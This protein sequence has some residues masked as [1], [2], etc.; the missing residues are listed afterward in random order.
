MGQRARRSIAFLL[1]LACGLP[2]FADGKREV[3]VLYSLGSDASSLWQRKLALGISQEVAGGQGGAGPEL[4]EERLDAV[5]TGEREA[6]GA[7][8]PYLRAKYAQVGIDAV[9]AENYQACRFL[10]EH[11]DLFPGARRVYV[12]HGRRGWQPPD[13]TGLEIAFDYAR[14]IAAIPLAMPGV[15][16]I[17]VVG[18]PTA[19]GKEWMDGV[20]AV[21][22]AYAGRIAFEFWDRQ[23]FD[24]L[25]RKAA[26][27]G[28]GSAIYMF[29][30]Y[31]DSNGAP[32]LPAEVARTLASRASA[33]VFTYVDSLIVPGVAGGYVISGERVGRAIGRIVRGES[34]SLA[35]VQ[36]YVL[37]HPTAQRFGLQAID[38]A[39]WLN[40]QQGIWDLYRWQIVAGIALI[41]LQAGLITALM[42]ALRDRRRTT[43][44][45]NS[46]RDKLEENV[47]E[48][49][50]ALQ[51]ANAALEQ[52]VTT[53]AL[54]GIGN[55]RRMTAQISA[56]LDRARRFRHPLALLMIDIDHFKNVNDSFG[57]DAGDRA[58]VAVAHTLAEG[59]RG[60]DC[61]A[62]F[63]GEEFVVLMPETG[64]GVAC[65]A[66]ERLRA[67]VAALRLEGDDGRPIA[68]TVS[69]GVAAHAPQ[70]GPDTPSSLLSRADRALYRAKASGRDLVECAQDQ[71]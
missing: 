3:L 71:L 35:D 38:G 29:P 9:V 25:Y 61:A 10:A 62:R 22:P 56:E 27:L 34:A 8:A 33:P 28:P 12:N 26:Q 52:L 44:A 37:D 48:R 67:Q 45:L 13:G 53:D 15:T 70:G 65:E 49:T 47:V 4:F 11:P 5:R 2:V 51:A 50:V 6:H 43:V 63:G 55:R 14:A 66:A 32:G 16:R 23:T 31:A 18:D 68:L 21:A 60:S 42:A 24:Q 20:R 59:L 17:A 69:I 57:H 7:M 39:V 36:A 30:T 58:I 46:E 40:R 64:L 41:V 1:A 19:R 54:T